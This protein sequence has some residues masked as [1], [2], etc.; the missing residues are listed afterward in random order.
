MKGRTGSERREKRAAIYR[1]R[2]KLGSKFCGAQN[3]MGE[4]ADFVGHP[5]PK[6]LCS[7]RNRRLGALRQT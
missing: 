6:A 1:E 7:N 2:Q 5:K 4:W 3:C